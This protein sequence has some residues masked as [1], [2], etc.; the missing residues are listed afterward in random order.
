MLGH[1]SD[2]N[3][4]IFR[5]NPDTGYTKLANAFLQDGRL[6]YETRGLLA[7]LMSR[8]DD[9][10]I[11]AEGIVKSGQ[12]GRDR[13]WRM[14]REAEQFGYAM[15]HQARGETGKF[16]KQEYLITDDPKLL[17]ERAAREIQSMMEPLTEKTGAD[18][19]PFPENPCA[20]SPLTE[21]P[22]TGQPCT[23][24]PQHTKER[25]IQT[26]EETNV[27]V[28]SAREAR[29][30]TKAVALGIAAAAGALPAA[31]APIEPP[32]IIQP[33]NPVHAL[34]D[35][36]HDAGG[37]ALN[38]TNPGMHVVEV[39]RNW[40][41]AGCDLELDILPIMRA[42]TA[43]KAPNSVSSW[44]YFE[45][46]IMNAKAARLA[47]VADGQAPPGKIQQRLAPWE[48]DQLRLKREADA[49]SE[50]LKAQYKREM[51]EQ[52]RG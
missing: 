47:P 8:P 26:T 1:N 6:S 38:L 16:K 19:L 3:Q 29:S 48:E 7:E 18:I 10:E 34:A 28:I 45:Q 51:E 12:A 11:R 44:K 33:V 39:P 5:A 36:L 27:D 40:L 20:G 50:R 37:R 23:A 9:W 15:A 22:C 13:V 25:Y 42:M 30:F 2:R 17:I 52:A 4:R 21:K 41:A 35:K 46:A 43:G 49:V 24:N 31:A 32:A 14:L